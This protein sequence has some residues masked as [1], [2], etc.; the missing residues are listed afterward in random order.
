[1]ISLP[2]SDLL[3]CL[4]IFFPPASICLTPWSPPQP[5]TFPATAWKKLFRVN[6]F[7]PTARCNAHRGGPQ[8]CRW[9]TSKI[10]AVL[11][12][13]DHF[14]GIT[15]VFLADS[16]HQVWIIWSFVCKR[17]FLGWR[18]TYFVVTLSS[19]WTCCWR[20]GGHWFPFLPNTILSAAWR[21]NTG[22]KLLEP[23][24][25]AQ[26]TFYTHSPSGQWLKNEPHVQ[27]EWKTSLFYSFRLTWLTSRP[28][29]SLE[30]SHVLL[31]IMWLTTLASHVWLCKW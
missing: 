18:K 14:C 26:Q 27:L 11:M 21:L 9:L 22:S 3:G 29:P 2:L 16:K 25:E 15:H 1:M 5:A 17:V 13:T 20:S 8:L 12:W 31:G 7:K 28:L 10:P 30:V 4:L 6:F 19:H 24:D 23:K